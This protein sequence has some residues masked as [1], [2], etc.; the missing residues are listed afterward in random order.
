MICSPIFFINQNIHLQLFRVE[1]LN[2]GFK[3]VKIFANTQSR[4]LTSNKQNYKLKYFTILWYVVEVSY[5]SAIFS[6]V[7]M[8][9]KQCTLGITIKSWMWQKAVGTSPWQHSS[10]FNLL[11]KDETANYPLKSGLVQVVRRLWSSLQ[12]TLP[13]L[14]FTTQSLRIATCPVFIIF[15]SGCL[16]VYKES[17]WFCKSLN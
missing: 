6:P 11:G 14:K 5:S 9:C 1:W 15:P 2:K 3:R 17:D 10:G 12:A 16:P 8:K 4:L 13:I 7:L